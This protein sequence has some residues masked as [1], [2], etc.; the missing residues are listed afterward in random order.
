MTDARD[1]IEK[2]MADADSA[3]AQAQ[4]AVANGQGE[5]VNEGTE[6]VPP[7]AQEIIRY[8]TPSKF[9]AV[10]TFTVALSQ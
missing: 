8:M 6:P 2:A 1:T 7:R 5:A 10:R 9:S 3:N 4:D